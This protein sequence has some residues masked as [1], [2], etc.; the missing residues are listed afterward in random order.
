[1]RAFE[2]NPVLTD[3]QLVPL[4]VE[5]NMSG[6]GE[7]DAAPAKMLVPVTARQRTFGFDKPILASDQLDPPFI[8]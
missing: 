8:E 3:V 1:M 4:L 2:F 6:G 7:I 5:R